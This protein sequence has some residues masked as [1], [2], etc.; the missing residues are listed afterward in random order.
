MTALRNLCVILL[1]FT[2]FTLSVFAKGPVQTKTTGGDEAGI[3]EIVPA[4]YQDRYQKWKDDLLS[5]EFGQRQWAYYAENKN[6]LLRIVV[7]GDKKFGAGTDGYKWNDNGELVGATITLGKNLDRGYPDPI[8][9]PVMNSLSE[10]GQTDAI[11]GS[12]LAATKIAHELGHVDSTSQING[13][14]FERQEKLMTSYYKIFLDNGYDTKDPRLV[15]LAGELGRTPIEVWE[16]REYWGEANAMRFLVERTSK[17]YYFCSVVNNI[18]RNVNSYARSY[19][20]RFEQIAD[21]TT[22]LC[23]R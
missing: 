19:E 15:R 18:L 23:H 14:L 8:Y 17:E 21:P 22:Q 11:N 5:T 4:V 12:I 6:F 1:I 20:T 9:Y 13:N 16:D 2:L 7:T 3:K 10:L